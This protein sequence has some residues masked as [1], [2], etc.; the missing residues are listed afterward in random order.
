MRTKLD[1]NGKGFQTSLTLGWESI[2]SDIINK[3]A[4][5]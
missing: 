4:S 1:W 5:I 2:E 3:A